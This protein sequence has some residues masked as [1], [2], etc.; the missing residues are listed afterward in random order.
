MK[1]KGLLCSPAKVFSDVLGEWNNPHYENTKAPAKA[2]WRL[3]T[4]GIPIPSKHELEGISFKLTLDLLNL[5]DM[6]E[7]S[8]CQNL[9]SGGISALLQ[10]PREKS[11][12]Q[13]GKGLQKQLLAEPWMFAW[14]LF[15]VF[16]SHSS[17][18]DKD[19]QLSLY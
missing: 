13:Q 6:E 7:A 18:P 1:T 12:K 5:W 14:W 11:K 15:T 10:L 16:C 3:E 19:E 9:V 8:S 4:L 17:F 2:N